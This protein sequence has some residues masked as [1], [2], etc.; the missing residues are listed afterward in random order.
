MFVENLSGDVLVRFKGFRIKI[1]DLELYFIW[2]VG[3]KVSVLGKN[4]KK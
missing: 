4:C 1:K 3:F 2:I